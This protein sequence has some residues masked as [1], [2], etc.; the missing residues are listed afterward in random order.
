MTKLSFY[1]LII[2]SVN[3]FIVTSQTFERQI[4]SSADDAEEKFDGSYVTTTSS[5]IEMM[6]DT[7]N[8]QGL[9]TLG[10]RFD[11]IVIPASSTIT[12]AYIQFTADGSYSGNL[13]MTIREKM[14]LIHL[15]LP[16]HQ[17]IFQIVL[18]RLQMYNGIPFHHG[19]T[20][21][22]VPDNKRPIYQL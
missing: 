20:I 13:T 14:L 2:L 1:L 17:I 7:W 10:F 5:D 16:A 15:C 18:L 21:N 22:R 9:Q 8:S 6:Y 19:Q 4:L 3:G 12:N 11:N